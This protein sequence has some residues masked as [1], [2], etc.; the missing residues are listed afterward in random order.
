VTSVI[1]HLPFSSCQKRCQLKLQSPERPHYMSITSLSTLPRRRDFQ[2]LQGS[3]RLTGHDP[4]VTSEGSEILSSLNPE[5][6]LCTIDESTGNHS[7]ID[8]ERLAT[9]VGC[10]RSAIEIRNRWLSSIEHSNEAERKAREEAIIQEDQQAERS[11]RFRRRRA[12][13]NAK[14]GSVFIRKSGLFALTPSQ[15]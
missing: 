1:P 5:E 10:H 6:T 14:E 4:T 3:I 8:S 9:E 11:K 12:I 7:T 15:D 2:G 13:F